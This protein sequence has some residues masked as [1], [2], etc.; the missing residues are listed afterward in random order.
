MS[1]KYLIFALITAIL[2]ISGCLMPPEEKAKTDAPTGL[3]VQEIDAAIA[4]N[5]QECIEDVKQK[6]AELLEVDLNKAAP[7][8]QQPAIEQQPVEHQELVVVKEPAVE[9]EKPETAEVVDQENQIQIVYDENLSL[10][11]S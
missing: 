3:S 2:F 11:D 7:Q 4:G 8:P 6:C 5:N 1:K 10:N 9:Q